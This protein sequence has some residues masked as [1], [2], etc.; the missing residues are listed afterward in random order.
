ML[1]ALGSSKGFSPHPC[2]WRRMIQLYGD[3]LGD[4]PPGF[5]CDKQVYELS[6]FPK[7]FYGGIG[8]STVVYYT[9][10]D[11]RGKRVATPLEQSFL[12]HRSTKGCNRGTSAADVYFGNMEILHLITDF[13][14][15]S[16]NN[17]ILV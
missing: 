2:H 17:D 3:R 6:F 16:T 7:F 10:E 13:I 12:E 5:A 4:C 15:L 11:C 1:Y 14:R 9:D 8:A